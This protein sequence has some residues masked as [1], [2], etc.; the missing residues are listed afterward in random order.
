MNDKSTIQ[1][2][3]DHLHALFQESLE[4]MP[5]EQNEPHPLLGSL[6][7]P[8]ERYSD[9]ELIATG[10]MKCIYRVF[11]KKT[12]RHV[13]LAELK[14][15]MASKVYEAFLM[16]ARLTGI[17]EHP[18]IITIHDIGIYEDKKPYFTMELKIGDSLGYKGIFTGEIILISLTFILLFFL[19][20]PGKKRA[21][22][23][24]QRDHR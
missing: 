6:I 19:V 15:D 7:K 9:R 8:G 12:G 11:D 1:I 21:K 20:P 4:D 18:N 16:E 13:A 14:H 23:M 17:L 24:L 5:Q 2:D 3:D 22:K 10:G